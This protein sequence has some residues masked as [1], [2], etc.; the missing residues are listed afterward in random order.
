MSGGAWERVALF[1]SKDDDGYFSSNGWDTIGNIT[2]IKSTVDSSTKLTSATSTKY[3]TKYD[4]KT[5]SYY[6]NN[7]IYTVGKI[8]DGTKEVNTGGSQSLSN[9]TKYYNWFSDYPYLTRSDFPFARRGGYSY[10][11]SGAGI[12]CAYG[13]SGVSSSS[14]SFRAVLVP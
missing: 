14:Y 7:I 10:D 9:T 6:G 2:G 13:G 12:F 8:G 3:A 4:N 1:N 5:T 11:G